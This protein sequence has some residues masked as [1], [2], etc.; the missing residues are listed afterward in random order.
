MLINMRAK[1]SRPDLQLIINEMYKICRQ[2]EIISWVEH[3]PGKQNIIPDA[4]SRNKLIPDNLLHNCTILSSATNSVQG[5]KLFRF[6]AEICYNLVLVVCH[7]V[8]NEI[9]TVLGS[10]SVASR[11]YRCL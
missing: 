5:Q 7:R 9:S 11:R 4:L 6:G 1:L 8:H 3:V 2:H 10:E